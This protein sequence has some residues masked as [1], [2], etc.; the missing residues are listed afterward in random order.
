MNRIK[1]FIEKKKRKR[2]KLYR[3]AFEIMEM[4][5]EGISYR[6]IAQWLAEEYSIKT[7]GENIRMFLKRYV[8]MLP[9]FDDLNVDEINQKLDEIRLNEYGKEGVIDDNGEWTM[10]EVQYD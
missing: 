8:V 4:H 7:S 1:E 6:N 3:Y 2:S 9:E 10:E 5:E